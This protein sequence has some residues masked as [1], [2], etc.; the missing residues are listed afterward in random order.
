MANAAPGSPDDDA[1]HIR[2]GLAQ[3]FYVGERAPHLERPR[4]RVDLLLDLNLDAG[5]F[6]QQR[7][8]V[9]GGR[10]QHPVDGLG[11][12]LLVDSGMGVV[13]L[14]ELRQGPLGPDHGQIRR[15]QTPHGLPGGWLRGREGRQGTIQ[16]DRTD[17][18]ARIRVSVLDPERGFLFWV[19]NRD[20][21]S[22]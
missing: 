16:T 17:P 12:D 8:G 22:A 2:F 5:A 19:Q 4:G 6:V 11:H 10:R 21:L 1:T 3:P 7:P 9:L 18:F 20:Q 15:R 13:S 14:R